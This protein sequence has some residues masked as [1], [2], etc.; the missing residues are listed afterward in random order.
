MNYLLG[1]TFRGHHSSEFGIG[2]RSINRQLAPERTKNEFEIPGRHGTIDFGGSVY[3]KRFFELEL[4]LVHNDDWHNLRQ[5][6]HAI[7]EWLSKRGLLIFDD[8]P[9]IEYDA[10][11]YTAV[12]LEQ[13]NLLPL[14][15]C[16]ITIEAQPFGQSRNFNRVHGD[17]SA[18]GEVLAVDVAGISA[19]AIVT[20]KN[21]GNKPIKG[22]KIQKKGDA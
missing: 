17:I 7:G 19:C 13:L 12:N 11:V 8:D 18:S 1:F 10:T 5:K 2:C 16:T 6:S 15:L 14:G 21:M 22:I 20:V 4:G 9:D 3:K